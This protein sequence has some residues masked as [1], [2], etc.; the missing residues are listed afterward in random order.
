M[1]N[2]QV[3][4]RPEIGKNINAVLEKAITFRTTCIT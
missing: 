2:Y 1:R 3:S 4:N